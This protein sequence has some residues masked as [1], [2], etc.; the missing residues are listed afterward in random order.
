MNAEELR[1]AFDHFNTDKGWRHNYEYMYHAIFEQV[2]YPNRLLEVGIKEGSSVAAWKNIFP[3]C[4]VVGIDI[5]DPKELVKGCED[6]VTHFNVDS[7][8]PSVADVVGDVYDVIIDDGAHAQKHQWSTFCGLRDKWTKAYVIEDVEGIVSLQG[9]QEKL[10]S[11]GFTNT[12]S[13]I[14]KLQD[15]TFT[16]NST[17]ETMQVDFY[18]LVI[19]R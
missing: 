2:G 18:S 11:A 16:K 8:R 10:T 4:T 3:N 5:C 12:E 19:Y 1:K 7:R 14:S 9:L 13:Y 6:V 15:V 17:K